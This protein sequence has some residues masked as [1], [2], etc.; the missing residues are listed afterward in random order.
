MSILKISFGLLCFLKNN[1]KAQLLLPRSS[2]FKF[3][4]WVD[5]LVC[6]RERSNPIYSE[7]PLG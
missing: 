7:V 1:G 3:V 6:D 2:A 4:M 5:G